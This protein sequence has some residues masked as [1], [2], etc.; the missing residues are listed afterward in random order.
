M[1][2]LQLAL[3]DDCLK[4][5]YRGFGLRQEDPASWNPPRVPHLGDLEAEIERRRE[6]GIWGEPANL[7]PS[8][9]TDQTEFC[10]MVTP[11]GKYPRDRPPHVRCRD[12]TPQLV[13]SPSSSLESSI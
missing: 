3:L 1:G 13:S 2:S 9:N 12:R 8:I 10:P 11:D 4:S 6:D 7:G 5:V